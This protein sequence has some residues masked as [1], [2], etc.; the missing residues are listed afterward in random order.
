MC[1]KVIGVNQIPVLINSN[2]NTS[3][4]FIYKIPNPDKLIL[5]FQES[6]KHGSCHTLLASFMVIIVSEIA[7]K[8]FFI[9]AILSMKYNRSLVYFGAMTALVIM[10][11]LSAILGNVA[12]SFI[13]PKYT[14]YMSIMLFGLFGL[15]M[16]YD[17]FLMKSTNASSEEFEE[18]DREIAMQEKKNYQSIETGELRP[19]IRS[20][21]SWIVFG[22][23]FVMTF[24]AEW[25]DRSQL[26]TI[27][28]SAKEKAQILN[29]IVGSCLGHACCTGLAVIGGR[30]V[31]KKISVK[32]MTLLGGFVFIVFALSSLFIVPVEFK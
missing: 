11:I 9:A 29:V 4:L 21:E 12:T 14:H 7:D 5:W 23:S 10:T 2:S 26:T 32:T 8:T 1:N 16:L 6:S 17:G 24:L 13:S 19:S 22:Q 27:V 31:A 3:S 28:I 30:V 18:V 15:K 25:G 20:N